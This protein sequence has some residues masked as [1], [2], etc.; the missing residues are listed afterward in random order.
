MKKIVKLKSIMT[1]KA[2]L[3][4]T[5]TVIRRVAKEIKIKKRIR[6]ITNGVA[7]ILIVAGLLNEILMKELI[8]TIILASIGIAWIFI[9][10]YILPPAR[11]TI[12]REREVN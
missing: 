7:L 12:I 4:G 2:T 10:T 5:L 1:P 11:E 6:N 9:T 3:T 8:V